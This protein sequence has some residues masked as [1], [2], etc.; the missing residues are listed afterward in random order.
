MSRPKI[1]VRQ[2]Q[3]TGSA[4]A[5]RLRKMLNPHAPP[6]SVQLEGLESGHERIAQ[7]NWRGVV[8]SIDHGGDPRGIFTIGGADALGTSV[9]ARH[10]SRRGRRNLRTGL[11]AA[12]E[13]DRGGERLIQCHTRAP[14]PRIDVALDHAGHGLLVRGQGVAASDRPS[15]NRKS[16]KD[17]PAPQHPLLIWPHAP[18]IPLALVVHSHGNRRRGVL[19][20]G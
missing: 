8:D 11:L 7:A 5:E 17:H 10:G 4:N 19:G 14:V 6:F 12:G 15:G 20:C 2:P 3:W 9:H 18:P 1:G 16:E 13:T